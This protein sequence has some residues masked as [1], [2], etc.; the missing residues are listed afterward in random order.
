MTAFQYAWPE[1]LY[2]SELGLMA[3]PGDVREFDTPP[4]FRW[5]PVKADPPVKTSKRDSAGE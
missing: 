3:N 1:T 4:D 2:Y 5:V